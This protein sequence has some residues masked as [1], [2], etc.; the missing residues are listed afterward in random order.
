MSISF[1]ILELLFFIFLVSWFVFLPG[2]TFLSWFKLKLSSIDKFAVSLGLGIVLLTLT[3]YLFGLVTF[4]EGTYFLL[5]CTNLFFLW[6]NKNKV[7]SENINNAVKSLLH[8]K[9]TVG[10]IILGTG[11]CGSLVFHSGWSKDGAF[12]FSEYRDALWHL[13][14]MKELVRSIPPLHPGFA[15]ETLTNYHYFTHLFGSFF[16]NFPFSDFDFYFRIFPFFLTLLYGI[17]V[18]VVARHFFVQRKIQNLA[19]IL[20]YFLG[21]FAYFLPFFL[22]NP[23]FSWHESSFWLS[24]PFTMVINPSFALS[25]S[26][27]LLTFFLLQKIIVEKEGKKFVWPL[28][29][30]AGTLIEYKVYAGILALAG[31]FIASL[32]QIV[33]KREWL[34]LKTFVGALV[35]T[36]L[37]F[38]P[39][40]QGAGGFLVF[41]PGW[42]LR[43]MVESPDRVQVVDWVLREETYLSHGNWFGVLR[44]RVL[45]LVIYLLGNLGVRILG[46]VGGI[47]LLS[48]IF[49]KSG[50]VFFAAT[51]TL[52]G[53]FM[54]LI[55]VQKG[56]IAN[57]LQFSYYSLIFLTLLLCFTL[58]KFLYKKSNI[59]SLIIIILT[60][61]LSLPTSVKHFIDNWSTRDFLQISSEEVDALNF[62][63]KNSHINDIILVPATN[64]YTFSLYTSVFSNRRMYYSDRLMSE[65]THKDFKNREEQLSRLF[66]SQDRGWNTSFLKN[67]NIKYIYREKTETPNF[68]SDFFPVQ[69]IYGNKKVEIYKVI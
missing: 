52:M 20:S 51:V 12:Y 18:Y 4:K 42:F 21:S 69:K 63:Q 28:I 48:Q 64:K 43:A 53:L 39:T 9:L 27:L 30:I 37:I 61:A 45:E 32:W 6:Q 13:G 68:D 55:F 25:S 33:N 2:Y 5:F 38:Y 40:A 8:H 19:I 57:T 14:L 47:L 35:V 36:F 46:L 15:P 26:L 56:S 65:N 66:T 22:R 11:I 29:L 31:L 50:T 44:L 62:L 59:F 24:Q 49:K 23:N 1:Y 60:I 67:N 16:L 54:P 10:L 34:L 3:T 58:D 7:R 17:T 41:L